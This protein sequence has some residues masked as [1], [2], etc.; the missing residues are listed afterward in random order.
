MEALGAVGSIVGVVSLGV[1][2]SQI[3][4]KQI[5]EVK[6]ADE[7]IAKFAIE[8]RGASSSV[9]QLARILV[10]DGR[11]PRSDKLLNSNGR[12]ALALSIQ[13]CNKVFRAI[14][15]LIAKSGEQ[16]LAAVETFQEK[17]KK[18]H[19]NAPESI[20]RIDIP[21]QVE[22]SSIEH[23]KWPWRMRTME[24]L[25]LDLEKLKSDLILQISV[26]TLARS[27]KDSKN[28]AK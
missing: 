8:L 13:A 10:D 2:I 5:D 17:V 16:V 27:V 12:D 22:L 25:S 20:V 9:E 23:L 6:N 15:V 14:T 18:Q 24:G 19:A 11:A 4:Q 3:L 26:V 28:K 1:Q 7:K 21:L